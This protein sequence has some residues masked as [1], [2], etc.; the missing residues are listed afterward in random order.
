MLRASEP[1]GVDRIVQVLWD[2]TPGD[3]R[4]LAA[5][6]H[7]APGL[8]AA[9][10]MEW[11][12]RLR[13]VGDHARCPLVARAKDRRVD[14]IERLR[15]AVLAYESFTDERAR[16]GLED[17]VTALEDDELA[18]VLDDVRCLAP[19]LSDSVVVAGASTTARSLRLV[20]ALWCGDAHDEAYA[21]LVHGLS[22]DDAAALDTETFAALVP[23]PVLDP[24]AEHA[25][26]RGDAEVATIL[27]SVAA[28]TGASPAA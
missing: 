22:Q 10:A 24:L 21:V 8:E 9:R 2:R 15:A 3:T 1:A 16:D 12:V 28:W 13:T 14:P 5:A 6:T 7:F 17:A 27:W 25:A 18:A 20:T 19:K 11:S 26:A 23:P 4:L